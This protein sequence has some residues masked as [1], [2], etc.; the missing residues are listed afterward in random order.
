MIKG[1]GRKIAC[2]KAASYVTLSVVLLVLDIIT[3]ETFKGCKAIVSDLWH[4][5][6]I[7]KYK[8]YHTGRYQCCH[9]QRLY[10]F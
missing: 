5:R 8:C 10:I 3:A 6:L 4:L 9:T 1:V 2:A 7:G